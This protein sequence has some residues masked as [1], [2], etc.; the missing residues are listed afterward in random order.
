MDNKKEKISNLELLEAMSG[1]NEKYL[2]EADSLCIKKKNYWHMAVAVAAVIICTIIIPNI[3]ES[4]AYAMQKIP[5]V[6]AYF[7]MVTF[8]QYKFDDGKNYAD[9]N[10]KKVK[11]KTEDT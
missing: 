5:F 8:R 1:I 6:G 7:E 3:N 9:I 10:L 4:T 2:K 11:N